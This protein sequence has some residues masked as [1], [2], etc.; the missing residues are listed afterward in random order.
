VAATASAAAHADGVE[1]ASKA[2]STVKDFIE[3]PRVN[4]NTVDTC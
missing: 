4:V 2:K 1:A 3:A